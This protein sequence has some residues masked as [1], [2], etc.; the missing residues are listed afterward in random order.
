MK[1]ARIACLVCA[2]ALAAG[3]IDV[4]Y[5]YDPEVD[6]TRLKSFDWLPV[7]AKATYNRL[8]IGRFH[9]A[10]TAELEMK[11]LKQVTKGPD[12]RIAVYISKKEKM[13]VESFGYYY[14][15]P[16]RYWRCDY[17]GDWWGAYPGDIDTYYYEEGTFILDFVDPKTKKLLW[18]GTA[19]TDLDE[20]T[21]P[22]EKEQEFMDK[23]ARKVLEHFPPTPK[24]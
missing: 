16:G 5:D 19:K 9:K 23:I 13:D 4:K 18:R 6:F 2:A 11:G 10:V 7:S 14:G 24:K 20:R 3:C 17:P 8:D 21:E 1:P 12:F 22:P 15:P